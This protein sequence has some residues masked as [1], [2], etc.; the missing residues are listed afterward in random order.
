MSDC[1]RNAESFEKVL[2]DVKRNGESFG[3]NISGR[4]RK[5]ESFRPVSYRKRRKA[6]AS[7]GN[8]SYASDFWDEDESECKGGFNFVYTILI[9]LVVLGFFIFGLIDDHIPR[10]QYVKDVKIVHGTIAQAEIDDDKYYVRVSPNDINFSQQIDEDDEWI[11]VK[12]EFYYNDSV[13]KDVGILVGD[14]DVYERNLL[15]GQHF[16]TEYW[17]VEEVYDDY[18]SALEAN[19]CK[20][21]AGNATVSKKKTTKDG[22][23]FLVLDYETRRYVMPVSQEMYQK[24]YVSEQV[25]CDFESC[26]DFIKLTEI[27]AE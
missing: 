18:D 3:K 6:E 19:P 24:S 15:G 10:T 7:S 27:A 20:K 5:A 17:G 21:F 26:G 22:G 1:K 11:E 14:Y 4:R 25:K 16:E 2:P 23:T 9:G 12:P 8:V 13:G